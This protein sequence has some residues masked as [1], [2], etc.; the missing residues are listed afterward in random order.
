MQAIT[1]ISAEVEGKKYEIRRRRE[2]EVELLERMEV[3]EA[4]LSDANEAKDVAEKERRMGES[5][6]GHAL[7]QQ[8]EETAAAEARAEALVADLEKCRAELEKKEVLPLSTL[9]DVSS[10]G[11]LLARIFSQARR[12]TL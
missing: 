12:G 3:L 11:V 6:L 5:S 8:K 1:S 4:Q 7:I 9:V 2:A 10:L